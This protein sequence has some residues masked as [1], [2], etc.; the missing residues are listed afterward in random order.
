MV[1]RYVESTYKNCKK[2]KKEKRPLQC[3]RCN[4]QKA[5]IMHTHTHSHYSINEDAPHKK[6]QAQVSRYPGVY[7]LR[8]LNNFFPASRTNLEH[9]LSLSHKSPIAITATTRYRNSGKC[10][11]RAGKKKK[12]RRGHDSVQLRIKM[13]SVHDFP[14]VQVG[15]LECAVYHGASNT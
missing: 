10:T 8:K 12:V 14:T 7:C 6:K 5:D 9:T 11:K 13:R 3:H 4:C 2:K 1:S 15:A